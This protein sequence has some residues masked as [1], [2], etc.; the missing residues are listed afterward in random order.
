M[1]WES[2]SARWRRE[3]VQV[4]RAPGSEVLAWDVSPILVRFRSAIIRDER[5]GSSVLGDL[6]QWGNGAPFPGW[7]G[8]MGRSLD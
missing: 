5:K 2:S 3:A 6:I 4:S 1:G 8:L 7:S